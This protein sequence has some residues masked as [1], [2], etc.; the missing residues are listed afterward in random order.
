[1]HILQIVNR[2]FVN[3]ESRVRREFCPPCTGASWWPLTAST[4]LPCSALGSSSRW[5]W[6]TGGRPPQTWAGLSG[7][8]PGPGSSTSPGPRGDGLAHHQQLGGPGAGPAPPVSQHSLCP[9]PGSLPDL[10]DG[11]PGQE[12]RLQRIRPIYQP[13]WDGGEDGAG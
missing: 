9:G 13:M 3:I 7:P 6:A 11:A 8:L 2:S 5:W 4:T 1:M 12:V 10:Q